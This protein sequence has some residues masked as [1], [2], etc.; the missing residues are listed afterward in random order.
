[1]TNKSLNKEMSDFRDESGNDLIISGEHQKM[2]ELAS[3]RCTPI[4]GK[5][6]PKVLL[7]STA[8]AFDG[9]DIK[10]MSEVL[11][12]RGHQVE[13]VDVN[14]PDLDKYREDNPTFYVHAP[15]LIPKRISSMSYVPEQAAETGD[16][17]DRKKHLNGPGRP[18]SHVPSKRPSGLLARMFENVG[19]E[20]PFH[21]HLFPS[22]NLKKKSK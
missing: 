22:L 1:M 15:M 13:I 10:F 17:H 2:L 21:N 3:Q 11:R 7:V 16:E 8:S 6:P 12:E 4:S 5:T 14:S 20:E 19:L 9:R 18:K